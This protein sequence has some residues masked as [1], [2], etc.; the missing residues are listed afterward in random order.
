MI[1]AYSSHSGL[2]RENNEDCIYANDSLGIYILADGMGGHNAGEIASNIAV[3]IVAETLS[4]VIANTPDEGIF[5]AMANAMNAAY[6]EINAKARSNLSFMGM[7]TTLVI[8]FIRDFK[9]Y[10]AH[11]GDSRSYLFSENK[12]QQIT[13]D[14]T[15]GDQLLAS[16]V[17]RENIPEKQFHTLTQALGHGSVPIPDFNT[18]DVNVGD[19]LLL[20]SDGLT[21]MLSDVEI[22]SVLSCDT[23]S[24]EYL[25]INLIDAANASGGHDN[26]SVVL[27]KLI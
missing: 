23:N 17:A 20:C 26:V 14:H 12:L 2:V 6:W 27:A 11:V 13:I 21:D 15:M 5:D 22:K 9:A 24:L 1:S 25:A 8:L 18:I 4:Q 10:V 19:L 16:G 3:N 7:G